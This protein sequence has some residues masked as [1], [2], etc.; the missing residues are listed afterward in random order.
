[1]LLKR[2]NLELLHKGERRSET[3][4]SIRETEAEAV[5]YAVCSAVGLEGHSTASDYIQLHQGDS[6]KFQQSLQ[7]IRKTASYILEALESEQ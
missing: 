3:T 7:V 4:K 1:M 6:E 2:A 5:A